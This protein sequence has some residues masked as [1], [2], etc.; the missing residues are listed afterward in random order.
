MV[1]CADCGFLAQRDNQTRELRDAEEGL[2]K[3]GKTPVRWG[4]HSFRPMSDPAPPV[5]EH[6]PLCAELRLEFPAENLLDTIQEERDCST[7][8][9]WRPGFTPKEHREMLERQRQ[10][11]EDRK[12]RRLDVWTLATIAGVFTIIGAVLT[13][14]LT[15]WT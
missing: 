7:F 12:A 9:P 1:K 4:E 14:I 15:H 5:Y 2:R 13:V 10:R 6:T 3:S 8:V 11:E